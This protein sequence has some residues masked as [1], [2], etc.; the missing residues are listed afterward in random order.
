MSRVTYHLRR[1]KGED[2]REFFSRWDTALRKVHQHVIQLPEEYEGFLL[3]NAL[4]LTDMETKNLLNF[5][6]GCIRTSSIK[7]WFRKNETRLSAAELG[8]DKDKK[9]VQQLLYTV[10]EVEHEDKV[11]EYEYDPDDEIQELEAHI[12][13]LQKPVDDEEIISEAEAAEILATFVQQR[14]KSYT[15]SIKNKKSRELA[16]GYGNGRAAARNFHQGQSRDYR[17]R[18]T[19]ESISALKRRTRCARCG[20]IGHWKRECRNPPSKSDRSD[21]SRASETNYLE[22]TNEVFFIGEQVHETKTEAAETS[23]V[24]HLELCT[25]FD[26]FQDGS[27]SRAYMDSGQVSVVS[28]NVYG[29]FELE[30]WICN[31]VCRTPETFDHTCATVDTG[32]QRMAIGAETLRLFGI[33]LP[34]ELHITMHKSINKFRSVHQTSVTTRVANIPCSLG[35]KGSFLK[36]AIFEQDNS[37]GAPFLISLSF[38]LHCKGNLTLDS[39]KGLTIVFQDGREQIPLHL[40][41]TGALRIPLQNFTSDQLKHLRE[42]QDSSAVH[43]SQ[44]FEILRLQN[45]PFAAAAQLSGRQDTIAETGQVVD[46]QHDGDLQQQA[47]PGSRTDDS[48]RLHCMVEN[49]KEAAADP[50]SVPPD[51]RT[52][53]SRTSR[54]TTSSTSSS[55]SH[56]DRG[57]RGL[58]PL[59]HGGDQSQELQRREQ[60]QRGGQLFERDGIRIRLSHDLEVT[61]PDVND[62]QTYGQEGISKREDRGEGGQDGRRG[63]WHRDGGRTTSY[64]PVPNAITDPRQPPLE[65]SRSDVLSMHEGAGD[66]VPLLSVVHGATTAGRDK[67]EVSTTTRRTSEDRLRGPDQDCPGRL[68]S[69]EDSWKGEQRVCQEDHMLQLQQT[70]GRVPKP[71]GH[72][73]QH[74]PGEGVRRV[75]GVHE[76]E[77]PKVTEMKPCPEKLGRKIR[78]ALK[79]AVAFWRQIQLIFSES[80]SQGSNVTDLMRN[81]NQEIC[82]E[83]TLHPRGSKRTHEIAEVMGLSHQQLRTV[84]E[85]YNPNCFGPLAK[86]HGLIAGKVFDITLG[87]DLMCKNKRETVMS[88]I[89]QVRPGLVVISP[90]CRMHSQLQNLSKHKRETI[91]ELMR[92]YLKKKHEGNQLLLFAI[93]VCELCIE[94]GI[95]FLFEHPFSASSWKHRAME[96]LLRNPTIF[97]SKADQCCYGL[98]GESGQPQRKSTGFLTNSEHLSTALRRQCDG[99]H[100]HEMIIGGNRSAKAQQYPEQLKETILKAYGETIAGKVQVHTLEEIYGEDEK[101]NDL[102]R[103]EWEVLHQEKDWQQIMEEFG[104]DPGEEPHVPDERPDDQ[105]CP[106]PSEPAGPTEPPHPNVPVREDLCQDSKVSGGPQALRRHK[107]PR[108]PCVSDGHPAAVLPVPDKEK[109]KDL[110]LASR[111]NLSRLLQRAHEGL[112]HPSKERFLRILRYAKAKTEILEAARNMKCSVCERHK[113]TQ[114]ARR[115][116]PP[117]ELEFNE[118]V[119]VDVVYLPTLGGKTRHRG[120]ELKIPI[121]CT[122]AWKETTICSGRIPTLDKNLWSAEAGCHWPRQGISCRICGPSRGRW[123]LHRS[124]RRWDAPAAR[125]Y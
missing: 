64:V 20:M 34:G 50:H 58:P 85:I 63:L 74:D 23:L 29:V 38:L 102:L 99:S 22:N 73:Q 56:G 5:T 59:H 11:S 104:E 115:S 2:W 32:C 40:G 108:G 43:E 31:N 84:A 47:Q 67:L 114:P 26:I 100:Q 101:I 91:P 42:W 48:G 106:D 98:K 3:I 122:T 62:E 124:S 105:V 76:V 110:P 97:M 52:G 45:P 103:I 66:T 39:D 96:R 15:E 80:D 4:L 24:G 68:P 28:E 46:Q 109:G 107:E 51:G 120:L 119:R 93:S 7:N 18:Q 65:E 81:M 16:R 37:S 61:E 123:Q 17:R 21:S 25:D 94:L 121:S 89:R 82:S 60:E 12:I 70:P 33:Q 6:H 79:Q 125:N 112:G 117:K 53:L 54:S 10:D 27:D 77:G 14:K 86:R 57:P 118:C 71:E 35:T 55:S 41:P 87:D 116:A 1:L 49:D 9:K 95:T 111:F 83:F 8:A 72:E 88:Y 30:N 13:D 69:H 92:A 113:Q 36:P 90:P 19:D 44:E 75:Q 78:A